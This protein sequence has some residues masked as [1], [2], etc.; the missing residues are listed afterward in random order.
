MQKRRVVITGVG[1]ITPVG[2]GKDN[3]WKSLTSGKS[4]I[5]KVKNHENLYQF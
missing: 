1:P 5:S 4:G 3:F 2:T